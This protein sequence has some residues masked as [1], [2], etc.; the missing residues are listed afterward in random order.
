MSELRK[1]NFDATFFITFTTVGWIDVF[2]REDYCEF[3]IDSL[4]FAQEE[5]GVDIFA[6]VIMPSH[7]HIVARQDEGQ[8]NKW[9][10][11]FKSY[12]SKEIVKMISKNPFESRKEWILYLFKFFAKG[13]KQN[14]NFMFW[15]KT[16]HPIEL[17]TPE[18]IDQKI[19]YIHNNPV[20]AGIVTEAWAYKYSSA[21]TMSRLKTLTT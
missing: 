10:G 2:T 4:I 15:Q 6:Y 12:T 14:D 18:V 16:S 1:A 11:N 7:L 20:V 13:T 19:D 9:M 21:N 3:I 5:R 8:L 17:Y